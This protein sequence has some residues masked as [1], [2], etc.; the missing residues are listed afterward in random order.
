MSR[1]FAVLLVPCLLLLSG[2]GYMLGPQAVQGVSSVHVP[3]FQSSSFRR[4]VD[5]LLTEAVQR[6]IRA[7]GAYR[8]EDAETA[9]TILKGRIVEIRKSP[10]SETRFDDPREVQLTVGAEVSWVD[11]RTGRIL[12]QK[13][14]PLGNELTPQLSSVSFA[15]EVGQSLASAQQD[16]AKRLAAGIVDL[17]EVPW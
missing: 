9:D 10:L 11:R 12:Q 4:N 7:R 13:S 5:Y 8:L 6:E 17:M 15:P 16:A 2:C 14:F 1:R 3:V